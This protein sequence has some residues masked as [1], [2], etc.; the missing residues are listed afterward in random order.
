MLEVEDQ[1]Q[2]YGDMLHRLYLK[3]PGGALIPLNSLTKVKQDAG[4]Q[5]ISH[6]G[7]L[8]SVTI[9]FNLKPGVALGEAVEAVQDL[10]HKNLPARITTD[11]SGTAKAF[12]DSLRNMGL[13][14]LIAIA[15][16][17]IVLG[18]AV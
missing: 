17:Y 11:F 14:L 9:S 1:Y 2:A 13:L 4:P 7:Q 12:Q 15:V 16:V 5:S 8:P 18:S 3:P 6:T 10:P